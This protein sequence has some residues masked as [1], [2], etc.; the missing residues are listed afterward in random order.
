[1]QVFFI[2]EIQFYREPQS[3]GVMSYHLRYNSE[4]QK[5]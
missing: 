4:T 2:E 5:K 3:F 1:M